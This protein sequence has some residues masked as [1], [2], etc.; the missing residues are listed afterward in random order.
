MT[1][2]EILGTSFYPH[3]CG[4]MIECATRQDA[5]KAMDIYGKQEAIAFAKFAMDKTAQD[6]NTDN[7]WTLDDFSEVTDEQLYQLYLNQSKQ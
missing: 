6:L 3:E 2:E 5:L 4:G 7:A 1:K